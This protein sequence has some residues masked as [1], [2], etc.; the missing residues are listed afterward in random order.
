MANKLQLIASDYEIGPQTS[1]LEIFDSAFEFQSLD[2]RSNISTSKWANFP[3]L[4]VRDAFMVFMI[5]LLGDY[6]KYIVH[7]KQDLAEDVYRTFKEQFNTVDY[8]ADSDKNTRLLLENLLETQ[9]FAVLLQQRAERSQFSVAFFEN[10]SELL[11]EMGL[12]AGGHGKQQMGYWTTSKGLD[13]PVPMY[14][15]LGQRRYASVVEMQHQ[16]NE[17]KEKSSKQRSAGPLERAV[18]RLEAME[19]FK[20]SYTDDE[21]DYEFMLEAEDSDKT[22]DKERD[23]SE[24]R[25]E[26]DRANGND[27]NLHDKDYGPL[28]IPGP[29][30]MNFQ[31]SSQGAS[32]FVGGVRRGSTVQYIY[33]DGWPTLDEKNINAAKNAIHNNLK[34]VRE[35]IVYALEK[36]DRNIRMLTRSPSDRMSYRLSGRL[37]KEINIMANK[38]RRV[39][40]GLTTDIASL[41]LIMLCVRVLKKTRPVNDVLQIFGILAQ[42]E[43]MSLISLIDESVWRGIL[44]ACTSC[45]GDFMRGASCVIYELMKEINIV[46][47]ALTYGQY[48]RAMSAVKCHVS[49]RDGAD[50]L[51]PFLHLE[52]LGMMWFVHRSLQVTKKNELKRDNSYPSLQQMSP[53]ATKR[54]L[55]VMDFLR[56]RSPSNETISNKEEYSKTL[57]FYLQQLLPQVYSKL[58]LVTYSG[59]SLS[60][61]SGGIITVIPR[62]MKNPLD[63][64][65]IK[66]RELYNLFE[67]FESIGTDIYNRYADQEMP[68]SKNDFR[69]FRISESLDVTQEDIFADI[70]SD[71]YNQQSLSTRRESLESTT[72][73][74]DESFTSPGKKSSRWNPFARKNLQEDHMEAIKNSTAILDMKEERISNDGEEMRSMTDVL[75]KSLNEEVEKMSIGDQTSTTKTDSDFDSENPTVSTGAKIARDNLS[76]LGD[77][78][79]NILHEDKTAIGIHSQTACACG[80]TLLDEEVMSMWCGY[81]GG[82]KPSNP[83][84]TDDNDDDVLSI[85]FAHQLQCPQCRAFVIPSLHIRCYQKLESPNDGALQMVW[86]KDVPYFSPYG[87]RYGIEEVMLEIGEQ[88]SDSTWLYSRRPDLY[89]NMMWYFNRGRFPSGFVP[90]SKATLNGDN[91]ESG[92]FNGMIF[93]GWREQIVK[94]QV[95]K[96]LSGKNASSDVFTIKEVFPDCNQEDLDTIEEIRDELQTKTSASLKNVLMKISHMS[97]LLE[98]PTCC[99]PVLE[100]NIYIVL[101]TILRVYWPS[102]S[103]VSEEPSPVDNILNLYGHVIDSMLTEEDYNFMNTDKR[104]TKSCAPDSTTLSIQQ[105]FGSLL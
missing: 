21:D 2:N 63:N 74:R 50:I 78:L 89:W 101:Y 104:I 76:K 84:L 93:T 45:G 43:N 47:D 17:T 86:S 81:S 53:N 36:V 55:G 54:N 75:S 65:L 59:Y 3:T 60:A 29:T 38:E 80:Y 62:Y 37:L 32:M 61:P 90:L 48:I 41:S 69:P 12:S 91:R 30:L 31:G 98:S 42:Y 8:L 10:A 26:L 83:R 94:L 1:G 11:R 88:I 64:L 44:V 103:T 70:L 79:L 99:G 95:E 52:E 5:D 15:L 7:P 33:Q 4:E 72:S 46:P 77:L 49:L 22:E 57:P 18:A 73:S 102:G 92:P 67:N 34:T 96:F 58:D 68:V 24:R 13:L 20:K 40:F 6:W 87:L 16:D 105:T 85:A 25:C 39:S 9:M 56:G 14:K 82:S 97:S 71:Q 28:I 27:L 100:R 35:G 23:N 66:D 51:D 19:S